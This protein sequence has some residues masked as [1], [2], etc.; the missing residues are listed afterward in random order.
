M[1]TID[2]V[3][4]KLASRCNLDCSYCYIYHMADEAWRSQP[5]RMSSTIIDATAHRL[6]E[7][8]A[9]QKHSFSIVFH[10]GEPLLIGEKRFEG[11]CRT[12]RGALPTS[13]GLHLQ[14]N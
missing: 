8:Y 10:G 7:L 13:C 9:E 6:R 3:L 14:T 2:T 5:G 11:A 12:L 1:I 4:L